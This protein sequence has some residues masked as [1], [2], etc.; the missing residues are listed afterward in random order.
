[1]GLLPNEQLDEIANA[2]QA[3]GLHGP[4]YRGV[5]LSG[6]AS[7]D[8]LIPQSKVPTVQL[9]NDLVWC[10]DNIVLADGTVPLHRWLDNAARLRKSF[11]DG[12]AF[13]SYAGIARAAYDGGGTF[14]K[15]VRV[16]V[17]GTR[18]SWS[19]VAAGSC[20]TALAVAILLWTTFGQMPS[21]GAIAFLALISV[22][23]IS[24]CLW[25]FRRWFK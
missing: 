11:P 4:D 24:A 14:A 18:L 22:V 13:A 23:M 15:E 7:A 5:L 8:A 20:T 16:R 21:G 10:N 12:Q 3:A 17:A 2:A 6:I 25:A 19:R 9:G 1:M